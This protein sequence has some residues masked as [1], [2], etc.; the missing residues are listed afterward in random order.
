MINPACL[1]FFFAFLLG[2]LPVLKGSE[3]I[4]EQISSDNT[5]KPTNFDSLN[6]ALWSLIGSFQGDNPYTNIPLVN[7]ATSEF[8]IKIPL[9]SF[10]S[11][12]F[13]MSE[14]ANIKECEDELKHVLDQIC[15]NNQKHLFF[16]AL[17]SDIFDK[18]LFRKTEKPL[19]FYLARIYQNFTII[20]RQIVHRS[21]YHEQLDISMMRFESYE[22]LLR[23][24]ESNIKR[25]EHKLIRLS[26][27]A[28]INPLIK[29]MIDNPKYF[30]AFKAGFNQIYDFYQRNLVAYGL[31][32][33]DPEGFFRRFMKD[34]S[35][36]F[37]IGTLVFLATLKEENPE[38]WKSIL[39]KID[40]LL[41]EFRKAH[42]EEA[43]IPR[44]NYIRAMS[45]INYGP[46]DSE[47][48]EQEISP[49]NFDEFDLLYALMIQAFKAGKMNIFNQFF[50]RHHSEIYHKVFDEIQQMK[51][52]DSET[53]LQFHF[54]IINSMPNYIKV[55]VFA[56]T[57]LFSFTMYHYEVHGF[58][59]NG[60]D[61]TVKLTLK[62]QEG[63][64]EKG[65]PEFITSYFVLG[66]GVGWKAMMKYMKI[67]DP[68]VFDTF[69]RHCL[70]YNSFQNSEVYKC[71][72]F[73]VIKMILNSN[74]LLALIQ[75]SRIKF[76]LNSKTVSL[77][78]K[79]ESLDISRLK[80]II[81]QPQFLTLSGV[82][83]E[84]E[85]V[86]E[87][88]RLELLTERNMADLY[89]QYYGLNN[90]PQIS[91]LKARQ[92]F[93]YWLNGPHYKRIAEIDSN[94]TKELLAMEH[95]LYK[96][97]IMSAI[98]TNRLFTSSPLDEHDEL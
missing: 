49:A 62:A 39:Q 27:S 30:K 43:Y 51:L 28:K 58:D 41:K 70:L 26:Q 69:L 47:F 35:P 23:D 79:D 25:F 68:V 44:L 53:E 13:D 75:N 76:T 59:M 95:P 32:H 40:D 18:K 96:P 60:S 45:L 97:L 56:K 55:Q 33:G 19:I 10:L 83:T 63:Q 11:H 81:N 87:I 6:P 37:K 52:V 8:Y 1:K 78:L 77:L 48:Y 71:P 34:K 24:L 92:I 22:F 73:D 80:P 67:S 7:K 90:D 38:D 57:N 88:Q 4:E 3:A 54:H 9:N 64:V 20:D 17:A 16:L 14:I 94:E 21:S 91:Y 72:S 66:R 31:R 89:L 29:F 42:P 12:H 93:K 65:Y 98:M 84:L 15:F 36:D 46:D 50:E 74:D 85:T 86:S 5:V 82:M 61:D 2:S